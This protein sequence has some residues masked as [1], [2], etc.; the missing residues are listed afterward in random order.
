MNSERLVFRQAVEALFV[1]G[2][3]DRMNVAVQNAIATR[4]I[5][6]TRLLPG[7]EHSVWEG[8]ILEAVALF[9]ELSRKDAL[10]E[11]GKRL[12]RSS[13]RQNPVAATLMPLLR[14]MGTAKALRRTLKSGAAENY[15]Q[16]TFSNEGPKSLDVTMSFVGT[17]P[18]FVSGT[19]LALLEALGA[20]GGRVTV[21]AFEAPA[22]TYHLEW[23]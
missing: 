9:P 20:K 1:I 21:A 17:I 14:V 5:D 23:D 8:A 4:G 22:A 15:N 7:Y 18:D 19:Q 3:A 11:L 16:V 13:I 10:F 2:L 6:V 12:A